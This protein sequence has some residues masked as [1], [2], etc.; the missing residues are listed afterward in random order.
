MSIR[1]NQLRTRLLNEQQLLQQQIMDFLAQQ[2]R[3]EFQ[4]LELRLMQ[5][6]IARWP[7]V[8]LQWQT[9]GL[10]E[11]SVRL[12]AIQ[13]ALS[14]ME[15]GLYGI[16]CDCEAKIELDRLDADPTEQR[17]KICSNPR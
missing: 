13:A 4:Q 17:C 15:I 2:N 10:L 5:L 16:C 8:L 6:T 9:P 1:L 12:E 11:V 7:E 3:V 14:Q